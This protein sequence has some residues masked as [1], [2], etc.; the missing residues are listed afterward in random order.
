MDID[1]DMRRQS[2]TDAVRSYREQG[3]AA[4]RCDSPVRYI[5]LHVTRKGIAGTQDSSETGTALLLNDWLNVVDE[6]AALGAKWMIVYFDTLVDKTSDAWK[7][8]SWAQEVHN[9]HVGLHINSR[10]LP[11]W[12]FSPLSRLDT[13]TTFIVSDRSTLKSLSFLEEQGY[14]LCHANIGED[15]R[16]LPCTHTSSIVCAGADGV[17][18]CCG[19]VVGEESYRLGN[20]RSDTIDNA[21]QNHSRLEPLTHSRTQGGCDGCPPIMAQRFK[22][23]Q[24]A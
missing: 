20:V 17:M 16:T 5:R 15:D 3:S 4:P 12:D 19:L 22:Q 6:S 14:T 18:F 9:M 1:E 2:V 7:I 21:M 23:Q 13:E 8:C 10:Y 11:N 24:N